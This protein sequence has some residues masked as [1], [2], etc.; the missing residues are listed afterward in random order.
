MGKTKKIRPSEKEVQKA[1]GTMKR[2][3]VE[4]NISIDLPFYGEEIIEAVNKDDAVEKF[5]QFLTTKDGQDIVISNMV[6]RLREDPLDSMDFICDN[7]I[8]ETGGKPK[9]F[10]V[11]VLYGDVDSKV[12]LDL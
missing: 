12:T 5:Q 9:F 8:E 11:E 2:Y 4:V 6:E 10:D 3:H 1:L 7:I